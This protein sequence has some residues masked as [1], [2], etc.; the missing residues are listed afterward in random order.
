[1]PVPLSQTRQDKSAARRKPAGHVAL[2]GAGPGAED[3]LTLRALRLLQAAEVVVHDALVP[4]AV[5]ALANPAA[6]LIAAGKRK[7]C[8]S[9]TQDEINALL[10]SLGREGRKVVRLKAGDPLI[11]GRAGEEMAAL[12]EAGVSHEIVPGI[13]SAIA[14]AVEFDLPLT[15]R[16]VSSSLVLTTGHDLKGAS[17]PD[18]ARLAISGATVAVYM[19][20]SNAADVATRLIEAGLAADTAVAVA[21]NAG[22]TEARLFHGTLSDLPLLASMSELSGPVMTIIG[23]AVAGGR[24]D[25]SVPLTAA[26]AAASAKEKVA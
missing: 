4:H 6:T 11:F 7:G 5:I 18:W 8:H 9:T 12:R 24:F 26:L 15:L 25:R 1:M 23:D 22:R 19:G 20:R 10:V 17:L 2:V 21:E 3:L 13:T 14:A 16:G